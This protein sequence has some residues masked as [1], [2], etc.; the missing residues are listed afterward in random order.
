M[1]NIA[2]NLFVSKGALIYSIFNALGYIAAAGIFY[3]ESKRKQYLQEPLLYV[4]FGALLGGL[5]G[6]KLGSALFVYWEYFSKNFFNIL[7]PQVGGKT[8]VGGLIGGF[9]GVE[10][11]KRF[12][13]SNRSTGDLFAPG[14]A[15][16]IAF[17]RIGCLFNGCCAGIG[18]KLP[19]GI[20]FNGVIR[21]PTQL[22]ESIFCFLLF[23]FLWKIRKRLKKE[24]ELFKIFLLGYTFFRFWIEFI[25][26]DTR[27]GL[28][29]LSIAQIISLIIFV[30]LLIYFLKSRLKA[31]NQ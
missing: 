29:G 14:L 2:K 10:I 25:R 13:K 3:K 8:L 28:L 4:L 31:V 11:T 1:D 21:H 27:A 20:A 15:L 6:S 24:G 30:I 22:Y 12:L 7:I 19:W 18:T 17:G 9:L 26:A 5:I 23:I 16:G